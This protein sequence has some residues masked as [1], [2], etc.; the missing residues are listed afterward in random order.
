MGTLSNRKIAI[1][2]FGR[3]GQAALKFLK[4]SAEYKD[5]DLWILDKG[6]NV[7]MPARTHNILGK[8]YLSSL[9]Q[10]DIVFRSPGIP[11]MHPK[12][13]AARKKGVRFSSAT[14]LFFEYLASNVNG[15]LS[16]VTV[17]GITGTKGKGTT[18]T[19]L[20]KILKAARSTGSGPMAGKHVFLAGNIGTPALEILPKLKKGSLVILE[21]SSFQLQG[22]RH[23]P[24][25]A[26]ALGVFPDH[27]DAHRSLREYY[28]AK[29]NI[30]RHQQK[31]DSIFYASENSVSRAIAKKSRGKKI[32]VSA[33]TVPF[34]TQRDVRMPGAHNFFNAVTAAQVARALKVPPSVILRAVR[35]FKG[36]EHRLELVRVI[37]APR[38][39]TRITSRRA[40]NFF[41]A[42]QRLDQRQSASIFFYNDSASTNPHTSAAAVRAFKNMP[43]VLIAGGHDKGLDY[44]PLAK[45]LKES[46]TKLVILYGENKTKI[47]RA[48]KKSGVK[49]VFATTLE[50]A[51]R[52]AYSVA[53]SSMVNGQWSMVNVIFSP[54]A[55]S[56][57]MFKNYSDRG[58]RF[59]KVV[60]GLT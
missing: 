19:L 20:Y 60:N 14:Q 30:A 39:T 58:K 22:L 23:S 12:L 50:S 40:Q 56:F 33:R 38:G 32:A 5:A 28:D 42:N 54:G 37:R 1:L 9:N 15:Q 6:I 2:G 36:N 34:L 11:Y 27:Q 29:A 57:D 59:K 47:A 4:R 43:H 13:V 24:H 7:K 45:A 48:I 53:R 44:A 55:A 35:A 10:F 26:V 31:G 8:E 49:I 16:H 21:L 17:I 3:E 25:I 51:V 52:T 18:S 41:R 46:N